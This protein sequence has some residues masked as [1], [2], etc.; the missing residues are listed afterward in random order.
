MPPRLGQER[1]VV[2]DAEVAVLAAEVDDLDVLL[3]EILLSGQIVVD[4]DDFPF[5]TLE[6]QVGEGFDD[7]DLFDQRCTPVSEW[8]ARSK[9][10]TLF[11][12]R[13]VRAEPRGPRN[14]R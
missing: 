11:K 1:T 8:A 2:A 10:R 13:R 7:D 14:R 3:F 9:R 5:E 12:G 6:F 4:M